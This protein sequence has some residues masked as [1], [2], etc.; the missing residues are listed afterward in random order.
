MFRAWHKGHVSSA[1]SRQT[2]E[3]DGLKARGIEMICPG[4]RYERFRQSERAS[5]AAFD[6]LHELRLA[7][8]SGVG[9]TQ[10]DRCQDGR[11]R[12]AQVMRKKT[13]GLL[14]RTRC[15]LERGDVGEV[16]DVADE[17]GAAAL[18][19]RRRDQQLAARAVARFGLPHPIVR[20]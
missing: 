4:Q 14:P 7:D 8:C 17:T 13:H 18:A 12:R 10:F 16:D 11:L 6:L 5:R 15:G 1:A 3:F 2:S 20:R 19:G 9:A